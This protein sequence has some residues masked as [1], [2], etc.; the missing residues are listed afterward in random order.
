MT[1][2]KAAGRPNETIKNFTDFLR[3][4]YHLSLDQLRWRL[5]E[6]GYHHPHAERSSGRW[7]APPFRPKSSTR[8]SDS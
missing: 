1:G 5:A 7:R 4:E 6:K 2:R 3:Q 8:W